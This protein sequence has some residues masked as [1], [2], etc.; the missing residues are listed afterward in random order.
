MIFA[1]KI[2]FIVRNF[3]VLAAVLAV[4]VLVVAVITQAAAPSGGYA[5]GATLDPDCSPGDADCTVAVGPDGATSTLQYN[6]GG[7]LGSIANF[8][9]DS[10]TGNIGIGTSTPSS[11]FTVSGTIVA[12]GIHATSTGFTFPDGTTQT[13]AASAGASSASSTGAIQ[14]SDGSGGFLADADNFFWDSSTSRLGVGTNT[15]SSTF[16][17]VGDSVLLNFLE[18]YSDYGIKTGGGIHFSQWSD[19]DPNVYFN[20][21]EDAGYSFFNNDAT[22][23]LLRITS[24]GLV[25]IGTSTPSTALSVN[26]E[27]LASYFTASSTTATSTFGNLKL[28][29][30]GLTFSDGTQQTTAA[31]AGASAASS[32]G[33]IQYSDGSGGFVADAGNFFW[34]ATN[35]R[36][37]VGTNSPTSPFH[38]LADTIYGLTLQ[39]DRSSVSSN[40]I[41]F[42]SSNDSSYLSGYVGSKSAPGDGEVYVYSGSRDDEVHK[43]DSSGNNV[44]EYT[45]HSD[46]INFVAV[47]SDGNVYSA[48]NDDEVHKIDSAGNNIW[49]YTGHTGNVSAVAVDSGGNVYSASSD[50]EVHK[51]DS[52]GNQV[53]TY[54]GHNSSVNAVAVDSDGNAYSASDDDGVHKVDSS[55]NQVWTYTGHSDRILAVT[56]DSDGNVY[57]G[58]FNTDEVHKV[59]SS[60]NQVWVYSGHSE[61]IRAIASDADGNVYS[62]SNDNSLHKIDSNGDHVWTYAGYGSANAVSVAVDSNGNVYSGGNDDIL[63]KIDS[64][65][66]Q[67]W[68]Y[69]DH[70]GFVLGAAVDPGTEGAGF[71]SEAIPAT[72]PAALVF[73]T[74]ETPTNSGSIAER[75]RITGEGLVGIG[76]TNPDELL[77]VAGNGLFDDQ[78][79]ADTLSVSTTTGTSTFANALGVGSTSTSL[80]NIFNVD[81]SASI[82]SSYGVFNA[83]TNGLIIEG[84]VGIG[85]TTPTTALSVNGETLASYFTASSTTATS[86]FGNLKLLG[87]GLTFSDG[88]QQTTAASAGASAA[89]STGAIQYSDGSGGFLADADNFFWDATND[90]L[91]IGTNSPASPFHISVDTEY[92]FTLQRDRSSQGS[93]LLRFTSS[94]NS[95]HLS[96]YIGSRSTAEDQAVYHYT[97]DTSGNVRKLDSSSNVEWTNS[98]GTGEVIDVAVDSNGNVYA[99]YYDEDKIK[100]IDS[101]GNLLWQ[102]DVT[103]P[104]SVAVGTDGYVY[105]AGYDDSVRKIDS[106]G[107]QVWVNSA[108]ISSNNA[109][110]VAVDTDGNV[111]VG[112]SDAIKKFDSDGTLIQSFGQVTMKLKVDTSGNIYS[113]GNSSEYVRKYDSDFNLLW[114]YSGFEDSSGPGQ[115]DGITDIAVD[116]DGNVYAVSRNDDWVAK[117]NSNGSEVWTYDLS[118]T[119]S[120]VDVDT[121][122]LVYVR[123]NDKVTILDSSGNL[124][125]V[126]SNSSI[127]NAGGMAVDPGSQG[128]GFW[129][130][131]DATGPAA[132]VFGTNETPTAAGAV[133]ERMRITGEGLVGIG[134]TAPDELLHVDGNTKVGGELKVATT[135][136]TSTITNALAVG[137]SSTD[138]ANL[139]TV[140]GSAVIGSSYATTSAPT[141]G[142]LVEGWV[143]IGTS[144]PAHPLALASGAHVTEGGTWTDASSREYKENFESLSASTT[145]ASIRELDISRWNYKVESESVQHIGPVAEE[146]H[147]LFGVGTDRTIASL[148]TSGVALRGVQ[149][150]ADQHDL[151][152]SVLDLSIDDITADS[153]EL[154]PEGSRFIELVKEALTHLGIQIKDGVVSIAQIGVELLQTDRIETQEFCTDGICLNQSELKALIRDYAQGSDSTGDEEEEESNDANEE[155]RGD[156]KETDPDDQEDTDDYP[157]DGNADD[158]GNE[159]E[160]ADNDETEEGSEEDNKKEEGEKDDSDENET[161]DGEGQ[162]DGPDGEEGDEKESGDGSD[163]DDEKVDDEEQETGDET[164]ESDNEDTD[165]SEDDTSDGQ[166]EETGSDEGGSEDE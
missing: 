112:D 31:S 49:T 67:V 109:M 15:P 11:L 139:F 19:A 77:H 4:S 95:S 105:T 158:A 123:E 104:R 5:P 137:T 138:T 96:G 3:L 92:G 148:D 68:T 90:R 144:T 136:G 81:G 9:Y 13:T 7:V 52:S 165:E 63:H 100:K 127:N 120:G 20:V 126:Y 10:G 129:D 130:T 50:Q 2:R 101:T 103:G 27:T 118:S 71:W 155:D 161:D 152:Y 83:P 159:N 74:N 157:D 55:G 85:T 156:D 69:T 70:A 21:F 33:A 82:G 160:D 93:N 113:G 145:L 43:V 25:G 140:S 37:G 8:F 17:V 125:S 94:D 151:L 79:S 39:R 122:G 89:S 12:N 146:F 150:L 163:E 124:V 51:I 44:W 57:S 1:H 6:D 59:D 115:F 23:E 128:A 76:T 54:T 108:D 114:T 133:T 149:I 62:A 46:D 65:G 117:I 66:D 32:T 91:G 64:N 56:V 88:T 36:L 84:S 116:D 86:T 60:G 141:D 30:T 107:N 48:S 35:D 106:S 164:D 47:D 154:V 61:G 16:E 153:G 75:M 166:S 26:G 78:L 40:L 98:N 80:A 73:G 41:G 53:W 134:T 72:G 131:V 162:G 97:G 121:S 22:N 142:L 143:G 102:F 58:S 132:L 135:T 28:L 111:Y 38:V 14:Y 29:G 45:G 87:T 34:D 99:A 119:G 147:K 18:D 24:D 42:N 110:G